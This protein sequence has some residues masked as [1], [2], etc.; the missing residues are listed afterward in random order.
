[1]AKLSGIDLRTQDFLDRQADSQKLGRNAGDFGEP[2]IPLDQAEMCVEHRDAVAHASQRRL[3]LLSLCCGKGTCH[4]ELRVG[5]RQ[6]GAVLRHQCVSPAGQTCAL[7]QE[8]RQAD[9]QCGD[10][11]GKYSACWRQV[12]AGRIASS[13]RIA[14]TTARFRPGMRRNA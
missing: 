6:N 2:G 1:M 10:A 8:Q 12:A 13:S 9:Q 11:A 5:C 7:H 4:L 3:K 14:T